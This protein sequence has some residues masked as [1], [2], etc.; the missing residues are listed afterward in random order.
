[1]V[2]RNRLNRYIKFQDLTPALFLY[3]VDDEILF[4]LAIAHMHRNPEYYKNRAS[5]KPE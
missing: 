1:M 4:I 3:T 2:I 5:Y